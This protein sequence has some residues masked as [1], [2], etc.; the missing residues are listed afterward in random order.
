M[1]IFKPDRHLIN[2]RIRELSY[3]IVG[4]TLD[5]G[6][7]EI[8]RYGKYF[9]ASEYLRMD[10][11]AA[12][13]ID[14]VGSAYEIPFPEDSFDSV[15]STQVFEHLADPIKAATE[16]RRV[17]RKGGC[18]LVTIPQVA[19]LHDEPGDYFRY[20]NHGLQALFGDFELIEMKRCGNYR[21][22]IAELH[23]CYWC[24]TWKLHDRPFI[25]RIAG[26]LI[27]WYGRYMLWRDT[28]SPASQLHT[29][30]WCAVFKKR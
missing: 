22:T 15:V 23:I 7:G 30:G 3:H 1:Y 10:P 29:I 27:S 28:D 20:T 21:A 19:P 11:I 18:V 25:G 26:K 16:I 8:N 4:R 24:D 9:E 17:L 14:I 5:V 12:P 6:A 13:G 2:Q